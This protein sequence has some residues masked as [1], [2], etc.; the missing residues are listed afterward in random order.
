MV[1]NILKII[2]G[3]HA[4]ALYGVAF[5]YTGICSTLLLFLLMTDLGREYIWLWFLGGCLSVI[6]LISLF[7]LFKQEKF[8]VV[9][10]PQDKDLV[11][12]STKD[13]EIE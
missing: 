4:T 13:V 11:E 7:T 6:S 12:T 5:S 9:R 10:A 8:K 2:Y 3:K 1:P